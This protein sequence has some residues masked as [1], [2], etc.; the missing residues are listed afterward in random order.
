MKTL[1]KGL[2][3]IGFIALIGVVLAY[4]IIIISGAIA[5]T[6]IATSLTICAIILVGALLMLLGRYYEKSGLKRDRERA[7][8]NLQEGNG[9]K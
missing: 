7:I 8:E 3:W 6:T 4:L 2:F 1:G 5:F 9:T